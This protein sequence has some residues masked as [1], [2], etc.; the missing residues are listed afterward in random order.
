MA[1]PEQQER[2]K[3]RAQAREYYGQTLHGTQDLKTS[4][5]CAGSKR[6]PKHIAAAI[7]CVH[8]DVA[9][10]YYGCGLTI[11]ELLTG[12]TVLDLGCG[13]GRDCYVLSMLVG[14]Q[15]HVHGVD[16]TDE[17]LA[18]ARK[19]IQYHT[20]LF[21][22]DS[23][24]V[25]FHKGFIEDLNMIP[26]GS[27]DV[28]VSNC[29]VN[30]SPDKDSVLREAY[31]VLKTGGEMFFSDVYSDRRIPSELLHDPVLHGECLSGALYWNDFLR[32][33]RKAGFGD[34]RLVEDRILAIGNE[35]VRTK[36]GNAKFFSATFRLFKLEGLESECEDYGQAVIYK[37]TIPTCPN[38]FV[39]DAHH[40][41]ETGKVFPVC[42][43]T[44][45]MLHDTR[46]APHFE[47]LGE[48]KV[49]YGIFASCGNGIPF[50]SVVEEASATSP[51]IGSCCGKPK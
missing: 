47:F 41:M 14:S 2:D 9:G 10:H 33:A 18:I 13:A 38:L 6:P 27:V 46:F 50:G 45:R 35:S 22:Y 39:L 19:Y 24:N 48:G 31:R 16:M 25:E 43:N 36:L 5:C 51:S 34:P 29:V 21:C 15:G 11:P 30:L 3:V 40:R 28:V 4:A 7:A 42:G 1:T 37:G 17:Q 49:H 44:Y 8:D 23:P 32:M 26:S 20:D 12:L